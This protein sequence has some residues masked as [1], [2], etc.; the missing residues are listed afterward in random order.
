VFSFRRV[1]AGALVATCLAMLPAAA[2]PDAVLLLQQPCYCCNG[3]RLKTVAAQCEER[4]N[5]YVTDF[6]DIFMYSELR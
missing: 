6:H 2:S 3:L 4:A 1:R 5:N